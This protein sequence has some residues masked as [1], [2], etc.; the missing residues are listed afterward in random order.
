MIQFLTISQD[1][2][3]TTEMLVYSQS[4]SPCTIMKV[5]NQDTYPQIDREYVV[6][7]HN[8]IMLRHEE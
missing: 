3:H 2:E 8:G 1:C 4:L 7:I 6:H 5:Q